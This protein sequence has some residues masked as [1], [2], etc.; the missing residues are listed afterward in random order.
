MML[1]QK[2]TRSG[3]SQKRRSEVS[4]DPHYQAK[5]Q[6]FVTLCDKR[7]DQYTT[8][9][10]TSTNHGQSLEPCGFDGASRAPVYIMLLIGTTDLVTTVPSGLADARLV[11]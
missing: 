6:S 7:T 11:C 2:H 3:R 10:M 1:L 4:F 5:T 8:L 9:S